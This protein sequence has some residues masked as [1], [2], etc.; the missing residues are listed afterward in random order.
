MSSGGEGVTSGG[1]SRKRRVG[2][3]L[4]LSLVGGDGTVVE[5]DLL[6]Q[7]AIIGGGRQL[8][9]LSLAPMSDRRSGVAGSVI[10]VRG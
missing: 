8:E 1:E 5:G 9:L 10:T 7:L 6:W 2:G 3:A 4:D